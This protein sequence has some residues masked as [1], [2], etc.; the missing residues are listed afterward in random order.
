MHENGIGK[1]LKRMGYRPP[2]WTYERCELLLTEGG[3]IYVDNGRDLI[4]LKGEELKWAEKLL[5][6]ENPYRKR[7]I[8]IQ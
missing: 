6:M 8:N 3:G 4:P 2:G 7:T 1:V 5:E